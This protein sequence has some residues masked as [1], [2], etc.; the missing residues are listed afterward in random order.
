MPDTD[1]TS[2]PP[3]T[4]AAPTWEHER[5]RRAKADSYFKDHLRGQREWYGERAGKHKRMAQRVALAIVIF[6]AL[7][8]VVQVL[9]SGLAIRL[10]TAILGA[11]TVTAAGIERIY[12]F[13]ESW[14]GYRKASEA[15]KRE[16]RLYINNAGSYADAPNEDAAFRSFVEQVETVIAEEGKLFWQAKRETASAPARPP[17]ESDEKHA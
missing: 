8:T 13:G 2:A 5:E 3:Q 7:T 10:V 12:L 1:Q 6:G 11:L 16:Y 15:M 14:M 4:R 17:E 9:E